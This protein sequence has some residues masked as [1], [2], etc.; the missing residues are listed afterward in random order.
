MYFRINI[1]KAI[2]A[3]Q[4][5]YKFNIWKDPYK[6]WI[7]KLFKTGLVQKFIMENRN[8]AF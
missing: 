7:T 6:L 2:L 1:D 3:A 4:D 5:Y 8:E